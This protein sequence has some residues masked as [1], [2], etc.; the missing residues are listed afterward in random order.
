MCYLHN[1]I[2]ML[3][4]FVMILFSK[5]K[6]T[7]EDLHSLISF[8]NDNHDASLLFSLYIVITHR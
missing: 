2:L 3:L 1:L 6:R 8:P 7:K 4:V 5:D